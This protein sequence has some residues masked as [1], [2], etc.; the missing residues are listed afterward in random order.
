MSGRWPA[1]VVIVAE[2]NPFFDRVGSSESLHHLADML[3]LAGAQVHLLWLPPIEPGRRRLRMVPGYLGPFAGVEAAGFL[4]HG[5]DFYLPRP[6]LWF[7]APPPAPAAGQP[8]SWGFARLQPAQI[9]R[10]VRRIAAMRPD[11]VIA[12]YFNAADIFDHLPMGMA[13]AI[14]T[15]DILALR[16]DSARAAGRPLDFDPALIDWEADR[17]RAADL[18]FVHKQAEADHIR[19][20]N[21]ACTVLLTPFSTSLP[22]VDTAA[23][24][25]PVA[26][27]VG[28]VNPPNVD[29]LAWLLDAVWPRV[30]ARRPEARLRVIGKVAG[31]A[32]QWPPGAEAVG[33]VEDLAAAYAG[34][35]VALTPL[36]FGSGLKIKL[37]EGLAHGLPSVATGP[38][39]DGAAPAPPA[40]LRVA[41]DAEGFA[42]A[43]VALFDATPADRQAAR[44]WVAAHYDR[45]A[46]ALRLGAALDA[47]GR[48]RWA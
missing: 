46:A 30:T 6:D 1:R 43:V 11:L 20:V 22:A 36:R 39:A 40:V 29:G 13:R 4:R 17:F 10:G 9:H 21:P 31:T 35:A 33:F 16:A 42:E 23:P 38:G 48:E 19:S 41:D 5:A 14:Y 45:R 3:N 27:F 34:A 24:R 26:V 28:G 15:H 32:A 12:D 47:W 25:P 8:L 37:I 44:D 7:R 18:C 2:K